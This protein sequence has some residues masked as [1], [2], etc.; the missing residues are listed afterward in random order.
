MVCE[1][2]PSLWNSHYWNA[3]STLICSQNVSQSAENIN[4]NCLAHRWVHVSWIWRTWPW[5]YFRESEI[6]HNLLRWKETFL[7]CFFPVHVILISKLM[8]VI[9]L[10]NSDNRPWSSFITKVARKRKMAEIMFVETNISCKNS[11]TFICYFIIFFKNHF[12]KFTFQ[13]ILKVSWIF[14]R[15]FNTVQWKIT[16]W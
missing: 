16:N 6:C 9:W 14:R 2:T 3:L 7:F 10:V 1:V 13:I 11:F 8:S 5:N 4:D 12:N 15:N